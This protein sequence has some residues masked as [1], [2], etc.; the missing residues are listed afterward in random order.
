MNQILKLEEIESAR[1]F[2]DK[3][4]SSKTIFVITNEKDFTSGNWRKNGFF[5]S[6]ISDNHIDGIFK[7]PHGS[8]GSLIIR[9]PMK[10]AIKMRMGA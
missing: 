6:H 3:E 8:A 10:D 9:I 2:L 4:T 1:K 7:N 5:T